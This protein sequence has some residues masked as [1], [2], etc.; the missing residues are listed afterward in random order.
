MNPTYLR[1]FHASQVFHALRAHPNISQRELCA[2]TGCD[3]STVS[4][5]IKRF[6]AVGLIERTQGQPQ[7]TRGRPQECLR[8][9][10]NSGFLLGV[11][12][13]FEQLMLVLAT[14]D[15]QPLDSW[16]GPLPAVPEELRPQ[17]AEGVSVM[18]RRQQ[19]PASEIRSVGVCLPGL[20]GMGGGLI[21]SPNLGW[22]DVDV[23]A[24]LASHLPAPVQADN[25]TNAATLAEHLFGDC[26]GIDDFLLI[27]GGAGIGGGLFMDGRV[28]RGKNGFAGEL[29]HQKV[30][31]NG[32]PCSCG[33]MGCLAAYVSQGGLLTRAAHCVPGI[34]SLEDLQEAAAAGNRGILGLLDESGGYV[35]LVL[36]NL[37]NAMN[38]PAVVLSG[39]LARLWPWLEAGVR[40][41]LSENAL[42]APLAQVDI[43]IS[44]LSAAPV[45]LGG[46]ALA[47]EGF[48]SL[49][50]PDALFG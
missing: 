39:T 12:L 8:I 32:H 3:K 36:S 23:V 15:G 26:A 25:D 42:P 48:T 40:R 29:G 49:D 44:R 14:L 35:G 31:A 2:L 1:Q 46:V 4:V 45:P 18:M 19:R 6:E 34:A 24:L 11:H 37:I 20:V 30:I 9:S 27:E 5:I 50:A 16:Q 47:L 13:E 33:A 7:G 43:V 28:Y 17:L 21:Y 10:M 41:S 38:P 22:R